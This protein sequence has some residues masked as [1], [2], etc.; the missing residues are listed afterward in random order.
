MKLLGIVSRISPDLNIMQDAWSYL[1]REVK[2]KRIK[3]IEQL[4]RE[5][6][7]AWNSPLTT[8]PQLRGQYG[9]ALAAVH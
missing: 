2:K 6:T 8:H 4:K 3:S 1:D 7:K 5:L 9:S